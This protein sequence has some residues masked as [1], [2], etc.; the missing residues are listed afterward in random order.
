MP[1]T[2]SDDSSTI[3][4]IDSRT[5]KDISGISLN[6][7]AEDLY[8]KNSPVYLIQASFTVISY[9]LSFLEPKSSRQNLDFPLLPFLVD[10]DFSKT[11]YF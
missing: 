7:I 10:S 6:K 5:S 8:F 3:S 2:N 9:Q 4:C 11:N 1:L